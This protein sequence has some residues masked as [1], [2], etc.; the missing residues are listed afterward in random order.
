MTGSNQV[1]PKTILQHRTKRANAHEFTGG[2]CVIYHMSR[3]QRVG[4]NYALVAAQK[5]AQSKNLP[6]LVVFNVYPTLEHRARQHFEFMLEGLEQVEAKLLELG[7][8]FVV[9][10]GT[11]VETIP[12]VCKEYRAATLFFDFSPLRQPVEERQLIAKD[13]SIPVFIVDTTNVVPLWLTSNKEEYAARTIRSKVH[14]HLEQFLVEPPQVERQETKLS[15]PKIDWEQIRST[16]TAPALP[17]YTP[18]FQP[19]EENALQVLETFLKH[20]LK[21]YSQ[22]RNDPNQDALSNLSPYLHYGQISSLRSALEVEKYAKNHPG[23]G[24]QESAAAFLEESIVR[25]ELAA[26]FCYYNPNY[27][28]LD[29]AKDWAKATLE[30]HQS[31][32]REHLYTLEELEAAQT[33]DDA[34]NACQ[35]EMMRTGKMHGY[36][37]MYWAKKILEWSTSPKEALEHAIILNDRYHLDGYEAN[38]YVG[39]L[40]AIAGIHDRP[41]GER[42]IFGTIRFMNFN[43]LK[44]KFDIQQYIDRWIPQR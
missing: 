7:I 32:P 1:A 28:N 12:E 29:A 43:G 15:F 38:G 11:P 8:P 13:L 18:P 37:R 33:Y 34:W 10:S 9:V 23:S 26:N 36:M 14:T 3:D 2:D 25:R 35:I 44:R 20:R 22:G 6:L 40:W 4:D 31:D 17:N 5:Y 21:D 19:G 39:I 16:I 41:W 30:K 42:A 24:V 27:L